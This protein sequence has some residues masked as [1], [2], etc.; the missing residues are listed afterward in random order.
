MRAALYLRVFTTET[1][2]NQERE[3]RL[4][5]ARMGHEIV[6]VI[7]TM[8]SVALK[9]GISDRHLSAYTRTLLAVSLIS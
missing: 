5:A 8:P 7:S 4:A 1:T 9:V 6:E 2:E 3:L